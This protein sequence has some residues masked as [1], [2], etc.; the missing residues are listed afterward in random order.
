VIRSAFAVL[1]L[2]SCVIAYEVP[3]EDIASTGDTTGAAMTTTS[4][5]SSESTAT[6]TDLEC[7]E[8]QMPCGSACADVQVDPDHCG[9]CDVVCGPTEACDR[10][11]CRDSCR[12]DKEICDRYCVDLDVDPMH[13]GACN[14]P[15]GP[16]ETCVDRICEAGT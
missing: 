6:D 3:P 12:D 1:A 2:T 11:E 7:T 14:T 8:Q 16:E 5:S 10:A 9:E 4:S 13:C 15:C